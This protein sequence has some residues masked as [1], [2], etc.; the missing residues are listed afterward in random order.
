MLWEWGISHPA[1]YWPASPLSQRG[2]HLCKWVSNRKAVLQAVPESERAKGLRDLNMQALPVERLKRSVR[3]VLNVVVVE[4]VP[5]DDT[6]TT[7]MCL[8]GYIINNRPLTVVS[9]DPADLSPLA[10]H[11]LLLLGPTPLP[12]PGV[13]DKKD[14]C[15]RRRW[16]QVQYLADV[17]CLLTESH[18]LLKSNWAIPKYIPSYIAWYTGV[19]FVCLFGFFLEV[20]VY[21][22]SSLIRLLSTETRL[23]SSSLCSC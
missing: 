23:S 8:A 14:C 1:S 18:A 13:F 16:R 5:F 11:Q 12:P 20:G 6:L 21:N 10:P 15:V 22:K 17:F 3:Q 4:K 9:D 2:I 19:C 7:F